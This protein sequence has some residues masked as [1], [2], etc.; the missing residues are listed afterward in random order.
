MKVLFIL[1]F[2]IFSSAWQAGAARADD[3]QGDGR[4]ILGINI[5]NAPDGTDPVAGVRVLGVSPGGPAEQAGLR[6]GDL[7]TRIAGRDLAADSARNANARLLEAM[8]R[9]SPGDRIAVR[10]ARDGQTVEAEIIAGAMD[11]ALAPGFPFLDSLGQLGEDLQSQVLQPLVRRWD[12]DGP[13]RGLELV[14]LSPALGRYF[15]ADSGLL[16]V[17]APRSADLSL[18]DGDVILRIGERTPQ[19]PAHALRILR[20][21]APGETLALDILR[22]RRALTLQAILP[23]AEP[24]AASPPA[25]WRPERDRASFSG[26][27]PPRTVRMRGHGAA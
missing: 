16:V 2:I 17:R 7:L 20:S 21:Y 22:D 19:D 18:Q 6:A 14:A 4:A 5:A 11:L 15:G 27:R 9:A 25:R 10:Y 26:L 8:E 1:V 3:G 23:T 12:R 13:L 24:A